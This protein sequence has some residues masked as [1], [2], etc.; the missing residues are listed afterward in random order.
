MYGLELKELMFKWYLYFQ[1]DVVL[2]FAWTLQLSLSQGENS[3]PI[4]DAIDFLS[5][6]QARIPEWVA[7]PSS[8]GFSQPRD[9]TQVLP[10]VG[11]FF[12]IW[13]SREAQEDWSG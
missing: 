3:L 1:W 8:R 7:M 10:I 5:I 11:R 6:L 2:I 13:A 4:L 9:W 12:T